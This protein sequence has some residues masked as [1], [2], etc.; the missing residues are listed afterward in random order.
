[1]LFAGLVNYPYCSAS[2]I[3]MDGLISNNMSLK[4]TYLY[5][6]VYSDFLNWQTYRAR[7]FTKY[8]QLTLNDVVALQW[9]KRYIL[10][11]IVIILS[12]INYELPYYGIVEING[13]TG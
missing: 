6:S 8:I 5:N 9:D 1:K 4:P 11:G 10:G 13:F 7:E 12:K 2:K 3:S